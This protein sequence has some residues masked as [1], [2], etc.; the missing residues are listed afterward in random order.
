MHLHIALSS[1]LVHSLP[2]APPLGTPLYSQ[3]YTKWRLLPKCWLL[4]YSMNRKLLDPIPPTSI[5]SNMGIWYLHAFKI[6][7]GLSLGL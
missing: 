5:G 6:P 7:F 2:S 1:L 4:K 3:A